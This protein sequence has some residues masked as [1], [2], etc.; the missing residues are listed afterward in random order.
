M[1]NRCGWSLKVDNDYGKA[2]T[3]SVKEFQKIYKLDVDGNVGPKT[4]EVLKKV[5]EIAKSGFDAVYYA[6]NYADVKKIYGTEKK[7][8]LSHYYF[9][10]KKENRNIKK[11]TY[12]A[13]VI[14]SSVT[15][16]SK[17]NA[18]AVVSAVQPTSPADY[19]G[20]K[21]NTTGK[22]NESVVKSG[23]I[24]VLLNIRKGAGKNYANLV[25]Y[26][27]LA[28]GTTIGICDLIK[29]TDNEPWFYISIPGQQGVKHGFALAK[30]I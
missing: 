18:A 2:T 13:T 5:Y 15:A 21:Y 24:K 20:F 1:L 28:E 26:P 14:A 25:S 3:E 10:G 23:K 29:G 7:N 27:T 6:N 4:I 17:E 22:Y 16:S 8:L 9:Y 30:F 12:S 19:Q 11:P